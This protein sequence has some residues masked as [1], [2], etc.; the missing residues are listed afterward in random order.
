[1][2]TAPVPTASQTAPTN[3]LSEPAPGFIGLI[4]VACFATLV[5]LPLLEAAVRRLTTWGSPSTAVWVQHLTLWVGLLGAVMASSRS[6][7]LSVSLGEIIPIGALGRH[8]DTLRRGA[9]VGILGWLTFAS[10]ILVESQRLSPEILGG[11]LP[12]WV[13]MAAMPVGFALMA[14]GT[15]R[16]TDGG[17]KA[18]VAVCAVALAAGPGV[19]LMPIPAG[20]WIVVALLAGLILLGLAGVPLFA[21]LGGAALL[22]FRAELVPV[23]AVPAGAY[24]IVTDAVLPSIPLFALAGMVLARGGSP[25]RLVELVQ[26][27]TGWLP[28][29]PCV[30]AILGCAFFT[31]I[32]GAS[33][34]TILA[35]GGLLLPIL[36]ASSSG[37][38][39]GL[40]LLT[41]SGSVGLLFFPSLPVILYAVRGQV[42]IDR[43]FVAAL[44]PALLLLVALGG[45]SLV[46]RR[47]DRQERAPFD[48]P[49]AMRAARS[50]WG[51]LLLPVLIVAGFFGG[52]GTLV[53]IS[54]LAALWAIVLEV[55]IHRALPIRN[56]LTRAVAETAILMGALVVV[57][58]MAF[59][60]FA[61]LVDAMVPIRAADW[62]SSVIESKWAFLLILNLLLLV[63]GAL[64]DIYSAIVVIVPLV[65][66]MAQTYGIDPAHLGVVFLANLELGYLTPPVG[67]NLFL[68]SL[69]FR[70]PLL[71]VWKATM[72]FLGIFAVWVLVVTYL[73]ILS[74]GFME[75]VLG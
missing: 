17:W 20:G 14:L 58:G 33:G 4:A 15:L 32:T 71:E 21:V 7:H 51:D 42:A 56:G 34:V 35:L 2:A 57:I 43:L 3:P 23:A 64:M 12:T 8:L 30:A 50:A 19:A 41:A 73:P 10:F 16:G 25:K 27:W 62:V 63:V 72:P 74:V 31:S 53:E 65:V 38:K 45:F 52:F 40:G 36:L 26:A 48:L 67:M 9:T 47:R 24:R 22:L 49:R 54:A 75:W 1:M 28:G 61:Y 55:G 66:P 69:T 46:S 44:L 37:E 70:R 5:S 18:R 68:S 59:G 60:L 11:W 29:G 39:Y 13:A 6:R